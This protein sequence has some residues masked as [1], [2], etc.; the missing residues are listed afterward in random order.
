[1]AYSLITNSARPQPNSCWL[2]RRTSNVSAIMGGFRLP[3]SAIAGRGSDVVL[4]KGFGGQH[5][6][7]SQVERMGIPG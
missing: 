6:G 1:M 2:P 5:V 3:H 4:A 7:Q